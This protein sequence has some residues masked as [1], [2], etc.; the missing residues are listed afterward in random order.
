[1]PL[2]ESFNERS[3][4]QW[5][6]SW[7]DVGTFRRSHSLINGACRLKAPSIS[8]ILV[9]T[10]VVQVV[11]VVVEKEEVEERG[12][13]CGAGLSCSYAPSQRHNQI[14]GISPLYLVLFSFS[15]LIPGG[16]FFPLP[17]LSFTCQY[18]NHIDSG[19]S[20]SYVRGTGESERKRVVS[21]PQFNNTCQDCQP[22]E[23]KMYTYRAKYTYAYMERNMN[24][25]R[26]SVI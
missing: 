22:K 16:F 26:S 21:I 1:M 17:F 25:R 4:G 9:G 18:H 24:I 23:A 20:C 10:R 8:P 19:D 11:V 2:S 6:S 13:R 3:M 14:G 5:K 7:L 12:S 15:F